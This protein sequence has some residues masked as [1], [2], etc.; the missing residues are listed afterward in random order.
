MLDAASLSCSR[1][2]RRVSGESHGDQQPRCRNRRRTTGPRLTAPLQINNSRTPLQF[3]HPLPPIHCPY[4]GRPHA[5]PCSG[6]CSRRR[7]ALSQRFAHGSRRSGSSVPGSSEPDGHPAASRRSTRRY[8]RKGRLC[9]PG[10]HFV[11]LLHAIVRREAS[12]TRVLA[13]GD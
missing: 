11:S 12:R 9:P 7:H 6:L 3:P 2:M 5:S 1:L 13:T 4:A 10:T 8:R